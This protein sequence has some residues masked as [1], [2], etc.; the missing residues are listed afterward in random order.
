MEVLVMREGRGA[1]CHFRRFGE[2]S[3]QIFAGRRRLHGKRAR[4]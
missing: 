3:K 1:D 4:R 2:L